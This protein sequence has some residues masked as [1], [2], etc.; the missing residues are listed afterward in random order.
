MNLIHN[1]NDRARFTLRCLVG[2]NTY[3][4]RPKRLNIRINFI[5]LM[6]MIRLMNNLFFVNSLNSINI[7]LFNVDHIIFNRDGMNQ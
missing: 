2:V 7:N 6:K 1:L 4:N 5:N 3:G